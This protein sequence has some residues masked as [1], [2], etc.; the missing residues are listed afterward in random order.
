MKTNA[1]KAIGFGLPILGLICILLFSLT[2]G[3]LPFV[4]QTLA[5][6]LLLSVASIIIGGF[7]GFLFG[8]PKKHS[9][10]QNTGQQLYTSNTNL[11]EISDWLTKLLVGAGLAQFTELFG[12]LK[13]FAHDIANNLTAIGNEEAFIIALVL[14][15]LI[16]G[17]LI[18]Y[19]GT[20]ILLP[21]VFADADNFTNSSEPR[22]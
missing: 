18:G 6:F 2:A 15:F 13:S 10:G 22:P 21:K 7:L 14:Y 19:L 9:G 20:R 4:M 17:F 12:F 5:T 1:L 8:I 11:E 3:K 16:G